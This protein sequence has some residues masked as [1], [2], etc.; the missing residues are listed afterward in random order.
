[1]TV[2]PTP[3]P[4][5]CRNCGCVLHASSAEEQMGACPGCGEPVCYT[6]GCVDFDACTK[7]S[8]AR[9]GSRSVT[10]VCAWVAAGLCSFCFAEAAYLLYMEAT[11]RI[12]G[13]AY[14]L[15]IDKPGQK[16]HVA[17]PAG[18]STL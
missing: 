5:G 18:V 8:A 9:D 11:G 12:P 15:R 6:C 17:A 4:V 10:V 14:Y 13:D 3:A 7:M 2:V 16:R 1:M